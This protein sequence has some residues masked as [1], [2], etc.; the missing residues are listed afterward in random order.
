[1]SHR[2]IAGATAVV[3]LAVGSPAVWPATPA[4]AAAVT[5]YRPS[6][7]VLHIAAREIAQLDSDPDHP[8][9]GSISFNMGGGR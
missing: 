7:G 1:M 3:A 6:D 2:W 8:D 5:Y 9:H 4:A